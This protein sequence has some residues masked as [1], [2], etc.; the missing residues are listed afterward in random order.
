MCACDSG[1]EPRNSIAVIARVFS[2]MDE[3]ST[4]GQPKD[5]PTAP[6]NETEGKRLRRLK[7]AFRSLFGSSIPAIPRVKPPPRLFISLREIGLIETPVSEQDEKFFREVS[8]WS[9]ENSRCRRRDCIRERSR[10]VGDAMR[11]PTVYSLVEFSDQRIFSDPD[12]PLLLV[13]HLLDYLLDHCEYSCHFAAAAD[14]SE[15]CDYVRQLT[16]LQLCN[17]SKE[18]VGDKSP[19]SF[20]HKGDQDYCEPVESTRI[21]DAIGKDSEHAG[22]S[23]KPSREFARTKGKKNNDGKI[24]KRVGKGGRGGKRGSGGGGGSRGAIHDDADMGRVFPKKCSW[25]APRNAEDWWFGCAREAVRMLWAG[26][27]KQQSIEEMLAAVDERADRSEVAAEKMQTSEE[28][29]MQRKLKVANRHARKKIENSPKAQALIAAIERNVTP[30]RAKETREAWEAKVRAGVEAYHNEVA[31]LEREIADRERRR[32]DVDGNRI[33][34]PRVAVTG[35]R[36]FKDM[37]FVWKSLDLVRGILASSGTT[38]F[39]LV[40]GD[41][42]G[43]D[44]FARQWAVANNIVHIPFPARWQEHGRY[45]GPI[46]NRD[47]L[48]SGVSWLVAFPGGKGTANAVKTAESL[49]IVIYKVGP[50]IVGTPEIIDIKKGV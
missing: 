28:L 38:S 4:S 32:Q 10:V 23:P 48:T 11:E 21:A 6:E 17:S 22:M 1:A 7:G 43:V 12:R 19:G 36:D 34:M 44:N 26:C 9:I 41:A 45:A 2:R 15:L 14:L 13:R 35:G 33:Y 8:E 30:E 20:L 46:R 37:E 18:W 24:K 3:L 5:S 50:S 29:A 39:E 47:M 31:R 49:G 27:S 25:R 42:K 16:P 40:H